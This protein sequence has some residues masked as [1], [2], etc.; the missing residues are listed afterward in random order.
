MRNDALGFTSFG[1]F[2][3]GVAGIGH[4]VQRPPWL[5]HCRLRRFGHRLQ[6]ASIVGF[7][8]HLLRHDQRVL[9]IHR[10]LHVVG[11]SLAAGCAHAARLRLWMLP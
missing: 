7:I 3:V 2:S 9:G 8:G 5:S 4:Y 10:G 11:R 1:L 6:T